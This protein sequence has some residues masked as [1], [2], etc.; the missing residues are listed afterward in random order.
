MR[1]E[2]QN[3]GLVFNYVARVFIIVVHPVYYGLRGYYIPLY[4]VKKGIKV[5]CK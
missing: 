3:T 5:I 2:A 4:N 1:F